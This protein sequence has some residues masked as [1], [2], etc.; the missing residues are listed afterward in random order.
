MGRSFFFKS[1][2]LKVPVGCPGRESSEPVWGWSWGMKSEQGSD[3]G[4][5][6]HPEIV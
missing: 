1:L 5:S 2:I 3:W 6:S 4:F